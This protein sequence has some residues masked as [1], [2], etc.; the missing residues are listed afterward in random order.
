MYEK[1][2]GYLL[3]EFVSK[4]ISRGEYQI[5][6][7]R[8]G[9][10]TPAGGLAIGGVKQ[11]PLRFGYDSPIIARSHHEFYKADWPERITKGVTSPVVMIPLTAGIGAGT[12][13]LAS[14]AVGGRALF[15]V[16]SVGVTPTTYVHAG[17]G[18][19]FVGA[20]A[21][22][23]EKT[24]KTGGWPAVEE[25][26]KRAGL[27]APAMI[28]AYQ[29]G[30]GYGPQIAYGARQAVSGVKTSFRPVIGKAYTTYTPSKIQSVFGATKRKVLTWDPFFKT[31]IY[32][33]IIPRPV[34]MARVGIG[35][36][37]KEFKF[38]RAAKTFTREMKVFGEPISKGL[39]KKGELVKIYKPADWWRRPEDISIMPRALPETSTYT[40]YT[41][42]NWLRSII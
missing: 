24:Y 5:E 10:Y 11:D 6:S 20:T 14:T 26:V 39:Y 1:D 21:A 19:A 9:T 7:L 31:R 8:T 28:G 4:T 30:T 23:M 22:G 41:R 17:I 25:Q 36:W 32:Q 2:Y 18:G 16:G 13:A 35:R 38:H 27:F 3:G 33:K 42:Y 12:S 40:F 15:T 37:Y 29:M 34:R